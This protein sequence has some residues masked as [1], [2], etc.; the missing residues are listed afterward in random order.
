ME[1]KLGNS[2]PLAILIFRRLTFV[3]NSFASQPKSDSFITPLTPVMDSNDRALLKNVGRRAFRNHQFHGSLTSSAQPT[4]DDIL[5][6]FSRFLVAR[7][8]LFGS[9]HCPLPLLHSPH[10]FTTAFFSR[11][12]CLWPIPTLNIFPIGSLLP[13][14]S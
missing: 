10:E 8:A 2:I 4:Q 5:S 11:S 7:F 3:S 12:V 6:L 13:F 9:L 1:T 14:P